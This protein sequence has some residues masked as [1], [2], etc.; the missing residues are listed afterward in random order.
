MVPQAA[1]VVSLDPDGNEIEYAEFTLEELLAEGVL[2]KAQ[3]KGLEK[4]GGP[5]Q[6]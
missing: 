1:A 3:I 2:L 4:D 5:D 6:N